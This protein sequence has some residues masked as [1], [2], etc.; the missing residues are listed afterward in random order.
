[1]R[2]VGGADAP[3]TNADACTNKQYGEIED[4]TINITAAPSCSAP[5]SL[6]NI[7][8]NAT[9]VN[10]T[11][12]APALPPSNGYEWAFTTSVTPP[13]SGTATT[14][15]S[16]NST[17]L[18]A[19]T[20]Y[21]LHVRS[22]CGGTFSPW[23]TSAAASLS[24]CIPSPS[25]VDAKGITEVIFG[26]VNN[27]TASISPEVGNYADYSSLAS[28]HPQAS[29]V[30]VTTI[31]QT[32]IYPYY[33]YIWIDWNKD[34]DFDDPGELVA[35]GLASN[36][37]VIAPTTHQITLSFTVPG[38]AVL[39]SRRM[40]IGSAASNN[41]SP[42]YG[43]TFG[44][45][46]DYTLE[47]TTG[48]ACAGTPTG[49]VITP[50]VAEYCTV[51][52][53]NLLVTTTS[54]GTSLSY[55]WQSS[56]AGTNT[57]TNIIGA[58]DTYYAATNINTSTDFRCIV[59][60]G[61]N[62]STSNIATITITATPA[63]DDIC[64]ATVVTTGTVYSNTTQCATVQIGEPT[65]ACNA[66]NN[67]VWY[68]Y[69]PTVSGYYKLVINTPTASLVNNGFW[70]AMYTS[71]TACPTPTLSTVI[72]CTDNFFNVGSMGAADS[73]GFNLTAGN[74]YFIQLD[75]FNGAYGAYTFQIKPAGVAAGISNSCLMPAT[76]VD[77]SPSNGNANTW[78]QFRDRSGDIYAELNAQNNDLANVSFNMFKHTGAQRYSLAS[79]Y[80]DR[81]FSITPQLQ[82]N[83]AVKLRM[84]FTEEEFFAL[85]V[86]SSSSLTP[87]GLVVT[88][89]SQPCSGAF[90]RNLP[91]ETV[92]NTGITSGSLGTNHYIEFNTPSF[93]SFWIHFPNSLNGTLSLQNVQFT[94][95][96]SGNANT[97]LIDAISIA[98]FEK[99][100]IE[101]S[102]DGLSFQ[103]IATIPASF[104][105][106]VNGS[107][108][109]QHQD[110]NPYET[111]SMYRVKITYNNGE[112]YYTT[113]ATVERTVNSNLISSVYPNP[114][115]GII[116]INIANNNWIKI[117]IRNMEGNVLMERIASNINELEIDMTRFSSGMYMV[118]A[119]DIVTNQKSFHKLTK[120]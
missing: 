107:Y 76:V 104:G 75:G 26:T 96:Q 43:G 60:C 30:N 16:S 23:A 102:K 112:E 53:S 77:V 29:V 103:K 19:G 12:V 13:S 73:V 35:S 9:S 69:T 11:W 59:S 47:V 27:N 34:F 51:G 88:K 119:M 101:K 66:L 71:S 45:F 82:P 14:S 10:H 46:E 68:R 58:N 55:Q 113:I 105:I 8:T 93:S 95:K 17:G 31:F 18:V 44:S 33:T 24:Y 36:A 20:T 110:F 72:P 65:I 83:T 91:G 106:V 79:P 92:I 42:C 15:T 48:V 52:S 32:L 74:T 38:S 41:P 6:T 87:S 7:I 54:G 61:G 85:K 81:N 40:R 117:S 50:S 3:Y 108:R 21:Y 109:F 64:N 120:Q 115:S 78:L 116:K 1:M 99:F 118:E 56:P 97:I 89:N 111:K 25:N 80:L 62:S 98:N 39:G 49:V 5:S 70:V 57:F 2:V 63:N 67:T 86:A 100:E 37:G 4:Y 28:Y 22:N 84:Y 94:A 90:T 114:T